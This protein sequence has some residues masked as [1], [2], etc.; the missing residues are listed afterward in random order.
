[1]LA[2]ADTGV[3]N[4]PDVESTWRSTNRLRDMPRWAIRSGSQGPVKT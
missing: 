1:M 2:D 4:I 3:P